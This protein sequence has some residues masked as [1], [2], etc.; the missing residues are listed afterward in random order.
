M[1]LAENFTLLIPTFNRPTLLNGLLHYFHAMTATFKIVILDSSA[2]QFKAMNRA[3]IANVELD[4]DYREFD[5]KTI[6]PVKLNS[7][8]SRVRT[9]YFA[10]C[11]DDNMIMVDA[12]ENIVDTLERRP[13]AVAG[14]GLGLELIL[15]GHRARLNIDN[16]SPSVDDDNL[17]GRIYQILKNYQ[18]TV[19]A[20]YRTAHY[21]DV[22]AAS[23]R[24][25]SP[26][27]WELFVVLAGLGGGKVLRV[28]GVSHIRR[29]FLPMVHSPWHP[30]PLIAKDPDEFIADYIHYHNELCG[31]YAAHGIVLGPEEKKLITKAHLVYCANTMLGG[32]LLRQLIGD[33][34]SRY[35]SQAAHRI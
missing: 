25:V 10:F 27:Y 33:D 8:V 11:A 31:F 28:D 34:F 16:M 4:I 7:E 9:K 2:A 13:D 18:N 19:Y 1:G 21:R 14:H 20:V 30:V 23:E 26:F 3:S 17:I 24:I 32:D 5:E 35:A 15:S 12:I 6:F 22:L 29:S